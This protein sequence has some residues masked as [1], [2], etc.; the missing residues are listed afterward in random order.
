[1][2]CALGCA[3]RARIDVPEPGEDGQPPCFFRRGVGKSAEFLVFSHTGHYGPDAFSQPIIEML[4]MKTTESTTAAAQVN[5]VDVGVLNETIT[6][7][8]NDP[9]LGQS[10]FRARNQ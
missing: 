5:G 10:R 1:M 9:G 7:I 6:A 4:D 8:K 3:G 2:C